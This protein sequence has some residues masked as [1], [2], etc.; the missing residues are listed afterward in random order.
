MLA[1]P[2]ATF[3]QRRKAMPDKAEPD[4]KL[5]ARTI[6]D[7]RLGRTFG[8]VMG[9]RGDSRTTNAKPLRALKRT[10]RIKV[11]SSSKVEAGTR[12]ERAR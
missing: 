9:P 1:M 8:S 12:R 2:D 7:A 11:S 3:I 5:V 10:V 4:P 6:E